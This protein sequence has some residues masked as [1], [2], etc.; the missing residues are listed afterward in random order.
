MRYRFFANRGL[1]QFSWQSENGGQL[2]LISWIV[3]SVFKFVCFPSS[4]SSF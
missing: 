3:V 1:S 4:Q 2:A